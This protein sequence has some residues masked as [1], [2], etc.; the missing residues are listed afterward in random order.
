MK[1]ADYIA[2]FLERNNVR[3]VY[4]LIGGM[5]THLLDALHR[6]G[7]I[8]IVSM[9]HEQA[10]AF[11][12]EGSARMTGTPGVALATSGPGAVN[13][14][15]AIGS[16]YF[17]SVP[18]VFIT[19]QVNRHELR[20]DRAV[21][22]A[23]FQ[24]TDIVSM[25]EPITKAAWLALK[26]DE[27][28]DLLSHAFQLTLSGRPGPVLIDIPMDVQRACIQVPLHPPSVR[29]LTT[30]PDL[31][32]S[33]EMFEDLFRAKRPL[34]LVGGGIRSAC[35]AEPFR[36][37][38]DQLQIPV[39][40]SLMGVDLL[41]Y[42]HALRV[43]MIG[44]YGNRWANYALCLADFLLVLGSRLDIRQTGADVR[45]FEEG[46]KIWHI[47]IEPGEINNS[48]KSCRGILAEL[49]AFLQSTPIQSVSCPDQRFK[50]W[51]ER[52]A[53]LRLKWPDT[54]EQPDLPGID[55]NS[56]M[57]RLSHSF[58]QASAFVV[59]VGQHQM[60]AA[61]SLE[62]TAEQ[63]FLTSGGM[64]SMGFALPAGIGVAISCP[65]RPVVVIAGDG[66]FQCNIQ[67][68]QTVAYSGLPLKIIIINNKSLGM[69]RQFQE[70]YFESRLQSTV[71]GYSAPDFSRVA[72][73]YGIPGRCVKRAEEID[74]ALG[75]LYSTSN[76]PGLLDV[77]IDLKAK[78]YPKTAFGK[79][80][81]E[82]EPHKDNCT[83]G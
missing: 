36:K 54:A 24:E 7:K 76:S 65:G 55:P 60:W 79:P 75:W 22:Q 50:T 37:L 25:A 2:L 63:R 61:Q 46:K 39:I 27:L 42:G 9:H 13:L 32:D 19:G 38:A 64:G 70:D 33:G 53:A 31:S 69:V 80:I 17:D 81:H 16:C 8:R 51:Q 20:G 47:D 67:E 57:H 6:R 11:A 73:A 23:G 1:V 15:T 34:I 10:A 21:R 29:R 58:P 14:L 74:A 3:Q 30:Q 44:T 49:G 41:P 59:D 77:W 12:A 56:L 78:A 48:L 40:H 52:I 4:E 62:L 66:G 18:T 83:K 26:P 71:I 43:G 68:L 5:I 35:A 72:E 45:S 28:P 82:M